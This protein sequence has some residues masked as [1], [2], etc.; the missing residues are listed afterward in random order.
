MKQRN[1]SI[2][3]IFCPQIVLNSVLLRNKLWQGKKKTFEF[4][5]KCIL[6]FFIWRLSV[7]LLFSYSALH[8]WTP[9]LP[10]TPRET[11]QISR[12]VPAS[13][14]AL[15]SYTAAHGPDGK[16]RRKGDPEKQKLDFAT[17]WPWIKV[18]FGSCRIPL[19]GWEP[20]DSKWPWY[21]QDHS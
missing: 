20:A 7:P 10:P 17:L 14:K 9:G 3:V 2:Q 15:R 4:F 19:W 11:V 18:Q 6:N 8:P 12:S 1:K 16:R 13:R 21:L 5:F